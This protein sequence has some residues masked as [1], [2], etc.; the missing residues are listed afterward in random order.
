MA[1]KFT[2]P[3]M[4]PDLLARQ[5]KMMQDA[6]IAKMRMQQGNQTPQGQMVSG[7]YI[8]PHWSQNLAQ[9]LNRYLGEKGMSELPGQQAE[10]QQMQQQQMMSQFGFGQPSP[11][12]LAQGLGTDAN[13]MPLGEQPQMQGGMPMQPGIQPQGGMQQPMQ[14]Q[15]QPGQGPML[16]PGLSPQQSMMALQ[17][18][19]P[20]EYMKAYNKQFEPTPKQ[21]DLSHLSPQQRNQLLEADAMQNATRDGVQMIRG[22]DG[23]I[24][25]VPVQGYAQ[26]QAALQGGITGAQ[27]QARAGFDLVEVPDGRGGV[28]MMPRSQAVSML[29]GGPGGQSG[30]MSGQQNQNP[31]QGSSFGATPPK[32]VLAARD[33]LENLTQ[34]GDAL[35]STINSL[36][37]TKDL[38]S[39]VGLK[40][41]VPALRGTPRYDFERQLEQAQSQVFLE[42][43]ERL[44]GGGVITDYEGSKAEKA[45]ARIDAGQS[46]EAFR[47]GLKELEEVVLSGIRRAYS[48]AGM[49]IPPQYAGGSSEPAQRPNLADIFGG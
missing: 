14:P 24:Y 32:E 45:I 12:A 44:K 33:N 7:H 4:A 8:A 3:P 42:G 23:Q 31:P 39:M 17:T 29:G 20:A 40:T 47:T 18:L 22:A 6:E 34:Q 48:N 46:P 26:S 28:Q 49:D 15:G 16:L 9:G 11:Q 13:P 38:D 30:P 36:S 37:S 21:R 25:S 10:L 19:G 43:Y 35:L 41:Y 27:E 1:T 2:S 5:M